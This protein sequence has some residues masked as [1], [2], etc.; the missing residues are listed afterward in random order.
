MGHGK[1][2][3]VK[4][5]PEENNGEGWK[6]LNSIGYELDIDSAVRHS[7]TPQ[8]KTLHFDPGVDWTI[9]DPT[10]FAVVLV[11]LA[12]ESAGFPSPMISIA[13]AVSSMCL[14]VSFGVPK[15]LDL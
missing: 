12:E 3:L 9:V 5:T 2:K 4:G 10:L 1:E 13:T 14:L 7:N 8:K 11:N 6:K 15:P